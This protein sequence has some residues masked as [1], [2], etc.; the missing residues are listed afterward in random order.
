VSAPHHLALSIPEEALR[1]FVLR[2]RWFGS[3]SRELG[4]VTVIAA[5]V[6]RTEEPALALA[7]VEI[8]FHA[9]T[10]EL[11]HVPI[12]FRRSWEGDAIG[13]VEEWT[14]YDALADPELARELMSLMSSQADVAGGEA[15]LEFRT[16]G[17]RGSKVESVRTMGA[18]Q[19]NTSLVFDE[20]VVLKAYRRVEAGVNP[21]LEVLRFLTE[22]GFPSIPALDGW[23]AYVG[24]PLEATLAI[25][26]DYVRSEGDGW[27]LAL[28]ALAAGEGD[29]FVE[30]LVLLGETTGAMHTA[31]ASN[32]S[33]PTFSPEEPSGEALGLLT[34]SVDEEIEDV[35]AS[36][37]DLPELAPIAGRGEEVRE[38]LRGMTHVG[39]VGKAIRTHGDY[40]LG[41]AI[42]N[43]DG[44]V[45]ID[46]EGEPARSVVERRRKRSP[47]RDVAGMLRSFAYAATAVELERGVDP[48]EGWEERARDGFVTGYLAE[49]DANLIPTGSSFERL[50]AV[51]ELEK[52]VYELRYELDNRPDWVRIPVTGVLRLL[53]RAPA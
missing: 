4:H 18:E 13:D 45:I 32:P 22:S 51:Y 48:P 37:P 44:W 38:Q 47:L 16:T 36:L 11:Y 53:E 29:E 3:K 6:L 50:L 40:H 20:E 27:E 26:Q 5:P 8:R 24:T 19:S 14:A 43:G 42:W 52:A 9:G 23:I 12:G 39:A 1:E 7:L 28:R 41:Q 33:D 17:R 35:F 10:H 30:Q 31:L 46:F 49:V 34:A 15:M 25:A 2:Q 21:E